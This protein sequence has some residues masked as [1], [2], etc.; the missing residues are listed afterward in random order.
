MLRSRAFLSRLFLSLGLPIQMSS[1]FMPV[2]ESVFV[3]VE[4][5]HKRAGLRMALR[6][7]R[8]VSGRSSIRIFSVAAI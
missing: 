7:F 8:S 2:E 5:R 1:V 3:V 6:N 4:G